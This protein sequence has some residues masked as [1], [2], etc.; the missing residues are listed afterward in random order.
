MRTELLIVLTPH[1]IRS[2]AESER[3]KQVES[4]RMSWCLADVVDLHGPAG[5]RSRTDPLG[6]AEAE[7]VYPNVPLE[8]LDQMGPAMGE[9]ML[10]T[11]AE[12]APLTPPA[13]PT[14]TPPQLTP[15]P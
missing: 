10:P 3:L 11:P 9:Q 5:L 2:R 4:A 6:A 7:V 1:V 13:A 12:G 8:Q 15:T 14:F